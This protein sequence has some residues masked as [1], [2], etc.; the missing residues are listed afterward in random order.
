ML[1]KLLTT[2]LFGFILCATTYA[3]SGT[4]TGTV[5][6]ANT[7]EPLIGTTV[8]IVELNR[9]TPSDI[10]G[11]FEIDNVPAGTYTLRVSFV[12][13]Q[14]FEEEIEVGS[15]TLTVDVALSEDVL[16]IG[17]FVVTALGQE[18]NERAVTFATQTVDAEKLNVT[19]DINVKT[20][21]AGKVAGVQIAGQ[22]GSKLGDFG[23]IRIR[24]AISLTNELAEP[25]YVVDGVPVNDPNAI[26]M[27][28]VADINV[29]KGPNATALYGQR[30]ESGVVLIS[31]KRAN[32][33]GVS[34]ELTNSL[35]FDQ[36]AYLPNY[37][38]EYGQGYSGEGEWS[39]FNYD[40]TFHPSYFQDLDG[41]RF[42]SSSY[43]DES[44][45]PKFD[46]QPYAPWYSW[47]PDSPYY[48][49]TVPYEAQENN[50]KDFYDTGVAN[51][52]GIA[53]NIYNNS[54]SGR[55]AYTNLAQNGIIPYS[56]LD[57]HFLSG[58][59]NYDV[60]EDFNVGANVN[61]TTQSVNG[62][63]YSDGYGNN[64]SGS[65]NS[66]FARNLDMSKMRELK[67][68]TTPDGYYASWNWWG[69]NLYPYGGADDGYQKATFWFNPYTWTSQYDINR[70]TD[71]LIMNAEASYQISNELELSAAANTDRRNYTREYYIPY[72]IDYSAANSSDFYNYYVNSFG[73]WKDERQE[74]NFDGRLNYRS[75][76]DDFNV[77][78]FVG[79]NLRFENYNRFNADMSTG[80][81][82]SGGLIIPDVYS[83][84]NSAE[85]ITPVAT[86]W[87]KKVYSV[88]AKASIGYQDFIYLDGSFRQDWSSALPAD[89]NGYG[90]PSIGASFVFS[91]LIDNDI[92]SYGKFR[93]GWAQVGNDV[94]AESINSAFALSSNPYSNPITGSSVPLLF[95]DNTFIDP[96]IKPALNSSFE[97]GFDLRF[98]DDRIAFNATYYNETRK[99]EIIPVSLSSTNGAQNYLTNAGT[100]ER[101]G[102]EL[103][104]QGAPVQTEDFLWDV[105]VNWAQNSTIVT[106]LPQGLDTYDLN[107]SQAFDFVFVTHKL[108]EE[109]GQLR[110]AG[111]A[112]DENGNKIINPNGTYAVEQNQFFGSVLPDFTGGILNTFAYKGLSLTAS[113]DFQKGG[114][115]FSLSEQW[116]YYS[117]LLEE[118]A[119]LNDKGNPKRDAVAD[120]GGV[121]VTGVDANGNNVDMYVP[122][123][124]YY[125]QWYSNRLAEPFIH[126]ASYV[127]LR[128][129]SLSY[130]LPDRIIGGFFN[131]ASVG[132]IARNVWLI[133]VSDDNV[134]GWDPSEMSQVYGENGQL[135]GTRSFGFNVRLTF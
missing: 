19:Q 35:T 87:E 96:N 36:V 8:Q 123:L 60:S 71:N 122:A 134:H 78:A 73:V 103:T 82:Q 130:N 54:Y 117:G 97:T 42:I 38:N 74:T 75:N 94:G 2:F 26:D 84:A 13:Y 98:L 100:S 48:G 43:A 128:E 113:I 65:F 3:Q 95:T 88:F 126:D 118:T 57:K 83:F 25:L 108:N 92:L 4:V 51:K 15:G 23:S 22:A 68:L 115:F 55:I 81:F 106:A 12:G 121:H 14:T 7:G 30:G 33:S 119:G 91:E 64:T 114:Q 69:P 70:Q 41:V 109:W 77:D 59:F 112:R 47:F 63:V 9:G 120:G 125:G 11:T 50:I 111:F 105:T 129:L 44:W 49:E 80:N 102:I 86:D 89:N 27:N 18:T 104:L 31:T 45:G 58:R 76:F 6:D 66:W 90:Y 107:T 10:D 131:S 133:A 1:K 67:N 37:Q 85:Q 32:R 20:G 56:N 62:D 40:N 110:G 53:V 116:G 46:G 135:P 28:N 34:V 5:T 52:A 127:K 21:L 39:T 101:E 93:A 24:G 72:N 29:L 79:G 124:N 99:D 16:G 17:E 132:V 61:F